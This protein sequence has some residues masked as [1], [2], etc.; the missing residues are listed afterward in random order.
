VKAL[1]LA[2]AI[3][4]ATLF[5]LCARMT[6]AQTQHQV[7]EMNLLTEKD[8][9]DTLDFGEWLLNAQFWFE[10]PDSQYAKQFFADLH[11]SAADEAA[12]RT[13][14]RDFNKRHDQ[15]MEDSCAKLDAPDWTPEVQ[16]KLI[17]DLVDATNDAIKLI[18]T[19]LSADGAKS[20]DSVALG[21]AH[22]S[23]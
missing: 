11:L 7:D 1:A 20:V 15:L 5:G 3:A 18:K 19:N 13:I 17:K 14:V 8:W 16:T 4:L 2:K 6:P 10:H 9:T 22:H 21:N 23:A 12:F